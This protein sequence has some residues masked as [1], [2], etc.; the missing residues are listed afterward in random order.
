M[1]TELH[2]ITLEQAK[3][4]YAVSRL[5]ASA[6]IPA[7]ADG[8]GF[9]SISRS[10]HELSIVCLAARVPGHTVSERAWT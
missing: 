2:S 8:D 6:S 1:N 4:E 10:A 9:V 5:D 7:W 3:G